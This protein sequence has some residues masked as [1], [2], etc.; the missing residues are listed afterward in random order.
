MSL[1]D[2]IVFLFFFEVTMNLSLEPSRRL[3]LEVS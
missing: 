3:E 1:I 2:S